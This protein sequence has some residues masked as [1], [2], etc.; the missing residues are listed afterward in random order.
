MKRLI[1]CCD[2]TWQTL[3]NHYPTNV[4]KIAQAIKVVGETGVHQ[5]VFYDDG[6][7]TGDTVDRYG[8]GAFGW[9]ID[10]KIKDAYR[11]L[12]FNYAPGDQVFLFGFSRGAYTVRSLAGLIYSSGLLNRQFVHKT[13]E[14][15]ELYR[16]RNQRSRHHGADA[17]EFRQHYGEAI[18]IDVLGCWDTVGSLGIPEIFPLVSDLIN[19]RYR[20]YDTQVNTRVRKAFHA[21]AVDEIREAFN[22]T[23]MLPNP[24]RESSQ[25]TQVWFPGEHACVGGGIA[26]TR[27]LSDAA[28]VWMMDQVEPLGLELDRDKVEDGLEPSHTVDFENQP[29]GIFRFTGVNHRQIEEPFDSLHTTVKRR[30]KD[31]KEYEP[32]T[33]KPFEQDLDNWDE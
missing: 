19:R 31:V 11:F 25:V 4:L 27:G 2:G 20:F 28:L 6:V 26:E 30:W 24:Q 21:V 16:N 12:S 8:G 29:K 15:Y 32:P 23:P 5:L 9:G 33:L 10:D 3:D 14:A 22:Y 17:V 13:S 7:G 1:V 18:D